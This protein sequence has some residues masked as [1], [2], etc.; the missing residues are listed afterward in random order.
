MESLAERTFEALSLA[1]S[2]GMV[3]VHPETAQLIPLVKSL[4]KSALPILQP[5]KDIL[6]AS[7][8]IGQAFAEHSEEEILTILKVVF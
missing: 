2:S 4:P 1:I 8:R 5:V 7:T 3:A 6:K